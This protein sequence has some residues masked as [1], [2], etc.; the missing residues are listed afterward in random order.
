M[1][2]PIREP[3]GHGAGE[4]R[5]NTAESREYINH[6][7]SRCG[8][9]ELRKPQQDNKHVQ[10]RRAPPYCPPKKKA[11]LK[12]PGRSGIS[13][14]SEACS[15]EAVGVAVGDEWKD[16]EKRPRRESRVGVLAARRATLGVKGQAGGRGPAMPTSTPSVTV[17]NTVD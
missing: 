14:R 16:T 3:L 13:R 8:G 4:R 7:P 15:G 9:G 6:R 1:R 2:S 12:F 17:I 5:D 10:R 11:K